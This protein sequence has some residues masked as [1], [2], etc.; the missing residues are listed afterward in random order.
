MYATEALFKLLNKKDK[1]V[2]L[3]GPS[4]TKAL[5]PVA[6]AAPLWKLVQVWIFENK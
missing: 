3:L 4:S 2:I 1:P 6:E 5:E